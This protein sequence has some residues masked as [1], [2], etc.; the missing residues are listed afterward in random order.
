MEVR[1]KLETQERQ[2]VTV[3]A[4]KHIEQ[5]LGSVVEDKEDK[6]EG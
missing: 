3:L 2:V 1:E 6:P 5:E 4:S